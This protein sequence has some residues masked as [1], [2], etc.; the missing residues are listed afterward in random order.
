[1]R[2][3][4]DQLINVYIF[5]A[6]SAIATLEGA[7]AIKFGKKVAFS[8]QHLLDCSSHISPFQNFG[9]D[10][11]YIQNKKKSIISLI[12][13]SKFFSSHFR[14]DYDA[15]L[16]VKQNGLMLLNNKPYTLRVLKKNSS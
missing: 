13:Q 2:L 9:C 8:E 15:L 10:G 12:L 7:Y 11:G 6:F 16:Y 1:M 5:I 3:L 14:F 4:V